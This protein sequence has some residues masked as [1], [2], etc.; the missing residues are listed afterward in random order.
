M[1]RRKLQVFGQY[2]FGPRSVL[3]KEDRFRVQ[4]GPIYITDDGAKIPMY[5][6]GVLL[7]D[8]NCEQGAAK[9]IE[10]FRADGGGQVVLWVG[11]TTRSQTIPGLLR[12]PYRVTRKLGVNGGR[13]RRKS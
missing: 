12:R 10:A 3:V 13:K 8:Q 2:R 6:R 9:W 1:P 5:E 11:K 4:G 7:F